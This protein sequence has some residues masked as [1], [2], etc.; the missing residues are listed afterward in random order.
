MC[1]VQYYD[2]MAERRNSRTKM[3]ADARQWWGEHISMAANK[4]TTIEELL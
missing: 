3:T 1:D 2:M 4:H